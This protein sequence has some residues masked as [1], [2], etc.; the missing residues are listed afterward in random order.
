MI[1]HILLPEFAQ[2][3]CQVAESLNLPKAPN[4]TRIGDSYFDG[5]PC[6]LTQGILLVPQDILTS[7]PLAYSWTQMDYI[8]IHNQELR[9]YVNR[10]IGKS[11][12]YSPAWH[13]FKSKKDILKSLIFEHPELLKDLLERYKGKSAK[14]Y[15]FKNDPEGKFSWHDSVRKYANQFP[16]DIRDLKNQSDEEILNII[17]KHFSKLVKEGL[18][19]E[20]YKESGEPN[21]EKVGQLILLELL[22]CS[23]DGSDFSV[24]YNSQDGS[25][26]LYRRSF[27]SETILSKIIL[28]YTSTRGI[29]KYYESLLEKIE[30]GFVLFPYTVLILIQLNRGDSIIST[31]NSLDRQY[32]HNR[33]KIFSRFDI[34]GGIEIIGG[35]K[36]YNQE[37]A[38][39]SI[40]EQ[41]LDNWMKKHLKIELRDDRVGFVWIYE[42][43]YGIAYKKRFRETEKMRKE[44]YELYQKS[45]FLKI[46]SFLS[47]R[48]LE[49]AIKELENVPQIR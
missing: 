41:K 46:G 19:F 37:K 34:Y 14:S 23:V 39:E 30:R 32:T 20:F 45:P 5:L 38:Q 44:D 33:S 4:S 21:S 49:E 7:L 42:K 25:I 18:C 17:L 24:K 8:T 48:T 11:W 28:K 2:F 40:E 31:L 16:L 35:R 12:S 13:D 29:S 6:Y 1:I 36:Q 22:E 15:N 27:H 43:Y 9:K 10:M 3:S 47:L 26:D